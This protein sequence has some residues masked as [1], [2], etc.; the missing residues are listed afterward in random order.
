MPISMMAFNNF[1]GQDEDEEA[2]VNYGYIVQTTDKSVL[3]LTLEDT[4]SENPFFTEDLLFT[5][6]HLY[7]KMQAAR[8]SEKEVIIGLTSTLRLYINGHI[9]SNECTCFSLH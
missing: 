7:Q 1:G 4:S 8:I 3:K 2:E 9:F 6:P 5:T